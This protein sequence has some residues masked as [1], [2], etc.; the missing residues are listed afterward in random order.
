ML[1]VMQECWWQ[2]RSVGGD[3]GMLVVDE[4]TAEPQIVSKFGFLV[5]IMF[6]VRKTINK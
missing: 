5:N 1:V 2:C 3:A 6:F 4:M